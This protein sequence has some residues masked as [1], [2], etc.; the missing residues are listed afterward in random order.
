MGSRVPLVGVHSCGLRATALTEVVA[1]G[2]IVWDEAES[3]KVFECLS[4]QIDEIFRR[5]RLEHVLLAN[6]HNFET[7]I[8]SIAFDETAMWRKSPVVR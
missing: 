8:N 3:M 7:H 1:Y 4:P 5:S 6:S 2:F